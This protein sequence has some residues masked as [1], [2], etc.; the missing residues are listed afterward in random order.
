MISNSFIL[1]YY[2]KY[3]DDGFFRFTW[4][5]KSASRSLTTVDQKENKKEYK[6]EETPGY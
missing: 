4:R 6:W 1:N 2:D 3:L 5:Q